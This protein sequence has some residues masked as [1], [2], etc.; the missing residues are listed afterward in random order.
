MDTLV[1]LHP[2]EMGSVIGGLLVEA[3]HEV[4]WVSE[5][6]SPRSRARAAQHGLEEADSLPDALVGATHLVSVVPPDQALDTAR[7]VAAVGFD[8]VYL[9][10]NAIAPSEMAA[11]VDLFAETSCQVCDGGII[12]P[13]PR[14][15]GTT[16]LVLSG[17]GANEVAELFAGSVLERQVVGGVAGVA[18]AYKVGFAAWTKGTAALAL[19]MDAYLSHHGLG[20]ELREEWERRGLDVGDRI[21][22][23]RRT[24]VPKGWRF[25]GEMEQIAAALVDAGLPAG[26]FT[27]AAEAY[28]RLE[29]FKDHFVDPPSLEEIREALSGDGS[30][31]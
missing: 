14:R 10:A 27:A 28:R 23:A 29:P 11:I 15:V 4:R 12:G 21:E 24:A 8:G 20:D 31:G 16:R 1:V 7:R 17:P 9:D 5:G 22:V 13:P 6:R 26:W 3:G 30:P 18:S 19:V 25:A 2:G